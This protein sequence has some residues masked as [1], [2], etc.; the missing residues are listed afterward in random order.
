MWKTPPID[1]IY[2]A[3]GA[4]ADDRLEISGNTALCYSSS[5]GKFYN[6]A[7]DSTEQAIMVNDNASYWK[8]YLGYPA[9]AFLLRVGVLDYDQTLISYFKGIA[10]KD[11]NQQFKNDFSKTTA[12]VLE[13]IEP[14]KRTEIKTYAEKLLKDIAELKLAKLGKMQK[15]PSGY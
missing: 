1:K 3:F 14:K 6:V 11:L 8:G 12:F 7:Y 10:W 13:K 9:I 4:L 5:G 15:P 2:E